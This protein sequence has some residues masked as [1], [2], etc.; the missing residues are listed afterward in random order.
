[1]RKMLASRGQCEVLKS[2]IA[3]VAIAMMNHFRPLKLTP[4][5]L[6]H[7]PSVE[8]HLTA[9][10]RQTNLEITG[11]VIEPRLRLPPLRCL[12]AITTSA[13]H[14]VRRV[15]LRASFHALIIPYGRA[16]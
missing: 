10:V 1:M 11:F 16:T 15:A 3:F 5:S 2:V 4:Y 14:A 8:V 9:A 6:F 7:D 13:A 12:A